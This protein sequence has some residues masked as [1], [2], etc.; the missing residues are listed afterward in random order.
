MYVYVMTNMNDNVLYTGV[1]SDL[2]RRVSQHREKLIEGFT[3]RYNIVKLVYYEVFEDVE[4]AI[5]REKQIKAGSRALRRATRHRHREDAARRTKRSSNSSEGN[6]GDCFARQ[7]A[8]S[9]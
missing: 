3:E 5:R 9:Q 7:P 8:G 1:T 2:L 4:A 6:K